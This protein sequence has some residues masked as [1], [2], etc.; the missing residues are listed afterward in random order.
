MGKACDDLRISC[1]QNLRATQP[2]ASRMIG[3]I[4][5]GW[6]IRPMNNS[7]LVTFRQLVGSSWSSEDWSNSTAQLHSISHLFAMLGYEI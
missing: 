2:L 5:R 6:S 4:Q 3:C 1:T 7:A